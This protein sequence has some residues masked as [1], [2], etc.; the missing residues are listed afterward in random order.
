MKKPYSFEQ[1][2][3]DALGKNHKHKPIKIDLNDPLLIFFVDHF[4]NNWKYFDDTI[5]IESNKTK[6]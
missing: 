4:F 3:S 5:I 6:T 2:Q 1:A